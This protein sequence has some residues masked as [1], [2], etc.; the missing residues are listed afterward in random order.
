ML[1][2]KVF[3]EW[4]GKY[5]LWDEKFRSINELVDFYRRTSIA[6]KQLVFLRDCED[7]QEVRRD[8][9]LGLK[10]EPSVLPLNYGL[11]TDYRNP[12]RSC[13][14]LKQ[15]LDLA[16]SPLATK[17]GSSCP[18]SHVSQFLPPEDL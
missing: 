15:I 14:I 3:R 1:H 17:T 10:L 9:G 16:G 13:L 11:V 12:I 8:R 2:F 18:G 5:H 4:S 6:K 7:P